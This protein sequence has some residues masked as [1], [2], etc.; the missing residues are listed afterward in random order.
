MAFTR[1]NAGG[2]ALNDPITADQINQLDIDHA[3]AIDGD[4]GGS[5]SPNSDIEILGPNKLIA[6]V[7]EA[8]DAVVSGTLTV[9]GNA[10]IGNAGSDAH[11]F[12]GDVTMNDDLSVTGDCSFG[13]ASGDSHE[14]S[15]DVTFF[16]DVQVVGVATFVSVP[17]CSAGLTVSSGG[18][19]VTGGLTVATGT[20]TVGAMSIGSTIGGTPTL[21]TK[22]LTSGVGRV[23][24]RVYSMPNS[25]VTTIGPADADRVVVPT[26]TFTTSR[27]F[28]I[29]DTGAENGESMAFCNFHEATDYLV[30]KKPGGVTLISLRN[31]TGEA[32]AAVA[33]R[34]G[35]VWEITDVSVGT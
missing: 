18:A 23:V 26:A 21:A 28:T 32:V 12:N 7:F 35:G 13:N 25:D 9:N 6:E 33:T 19:N 31:V 29:D 1:V 24:G 5:Y 4:D 30:V 3:N 20:T 8:A 27:N 2:W 17:V 22:L 14:F 11:T 15:G 34:I 16:D 10:T